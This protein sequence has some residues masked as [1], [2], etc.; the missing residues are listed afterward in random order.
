MSITEKLTFE[1]GMQAGPISDG[2][3]GLQEVHKR[4]EKLEEQV[5]SSAVKELGELAAAVRKHASDE[6]KT[7]GLTK[8]AQTT[9]EES[10]KAAKDIRQALKTL[11]GSLAGGGKAMGEKM[12]G[13]LFQCAC[14]DRDLSGPALGCLPEDARI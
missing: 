7:T 13:V 12:A 5:R 6:P 3:R 9:L 10:L 2:V 8:G 14:F 1:L 4:Q 11:K